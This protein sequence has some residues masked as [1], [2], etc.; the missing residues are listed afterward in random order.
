MARTAHRKIMAGGRVP[1]LLF[2]LEADPEERT[3]LGIDPANASSIVTLRGLLG[4]A[5]DAID[6]DSVR[7]TRLRVPEDCSDSACCR[8]EPLIP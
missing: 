5:W 4:S 3:T 8:A 7:G 6:S 2:D 1:D